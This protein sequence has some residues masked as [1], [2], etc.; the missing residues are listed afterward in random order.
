MKN[1]HLAY[2][3][4]YNG[5]N[6]QLGRDIV[7]MD[8][9]KGTKEV[10]EGAVEEL[11]LEAKKDSRSNKPKL[12]DELYYTTRS[13]ERATEGFGNLSKTGEYPIQIGGY[14]G[15]NRELGRD[16][17]KM[18]YDETN[19]VFNGMGEEL[20]TQ[21]HEDLENGPKPVKNLHKLIDDIERVEIGFDHIWK[22]CKYRTTKI[23]RDK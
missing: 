5:T 2:I 17:I 1:K 23:Y 12:S 15:T 19:K 9:E 21:S 10:L 13:L 7:K 20:T 16:I 6:R 4:G 22:I 8:Y 11:R 18:A 14:E 3:E